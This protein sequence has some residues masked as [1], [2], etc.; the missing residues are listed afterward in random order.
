MKK[1]YDFTRRESGFILPYVLVIVTI[2]LIV[3]TASIKIY[4]QEFKVTH[5]YLEQIK[6]ETLMQMAYVQFHEDY[7]MNEASQ[8][9]TEYEFP[10]G[11]VD[12]T[13][14]PITDEPDTLYFVVDTDKATRYTFLKKI[15]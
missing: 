15:K 6:I 11:S 2:A 7:D 9:R 13:Y 14:S 8:I 3:M 10:S 12:V 5:H 4:E 1:Y